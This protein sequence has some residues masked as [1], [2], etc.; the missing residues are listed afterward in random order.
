LYRVNYDLIINNIKSDIERWS[1]YPMSFSDR[2]KGI[3]MNV[4]PRLLY[5]F[6][7]LPVEILPKQFLEWDKII[8]RYDIERKVAWLFRVLKIITVKHSCVPS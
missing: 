3:K 7:S 4:L 5:L 2:I 1:T 6:Q 8:S